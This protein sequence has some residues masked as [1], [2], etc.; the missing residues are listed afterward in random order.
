[1]VK[2]S[3]SVRKMASELNVSLRSMPNL[4]KNDL[5]LKSF[6]QDNVLFI[7]EKLLTIEEDNNKMNNL[8]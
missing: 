2:P 4:V 3:I 6:K 1:M 7:V 8:H 5:Q